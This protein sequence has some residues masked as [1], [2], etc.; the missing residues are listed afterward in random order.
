MSF[1]PSH[2]R[3][4]RAIVV[5]PDFHL[6]TDSVGT[7]KRAAELGLKDPK[8]VSATRLTRVCLLNVLSGCAF[9]VA[10]G[11]CLTTWTC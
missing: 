9:S 6:N 11:R 8:Q 4:Y 3:S 1:W 5:L 2:V 10:L 7:K